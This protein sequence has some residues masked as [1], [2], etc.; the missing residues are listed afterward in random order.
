MLKSILSLAAALA[1]AAPGYAE[2]YLSAPS[3]QPGAPLHPRSLQSA[4]NADTVLNEPISVNGVNA[5]LKVG[6]ING[7]T[8][9]GQLRRLLRSFPAARVS[10][11]AESAK[12]S[13][14]AD[15][16]SFRLFLLQLSPASPMIQF[17]VESPAKIPSR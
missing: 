15:K 4:L 10:A 8:L 1:L 17:S 5:T 11:N 13:I 3:A 2:V 9:S 7:E 14:N 6:L 12:I 16:R